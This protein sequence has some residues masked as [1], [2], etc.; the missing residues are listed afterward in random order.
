MAE[1]EAF[2]SKATSTLSSDEQAELSRA[3][4]T[5]SN[6]EEVTLATRGRTLSDMMSGQSIHRS[7]HEIYSKFTQNELEE[8]FARFKQYDLDNSGFITPTNLKL[9]F[10]ALDMPEVTDVQCQNMV[11][12]VAILTGHDNDGKMSFEEFLAMMR[13]DTTEDAL[14]KATSQRQLV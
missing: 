13:E 12:E 10:E 14:A 1:D 5:L 11:A 7:P 2:L 6:G 4:S 8:H 9:I 3:L